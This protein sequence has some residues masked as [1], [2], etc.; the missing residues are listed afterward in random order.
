[1]GEVFPHAESG[2][3]IKK[4]RIKVQLSLKHLLAV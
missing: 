4:K 3:K 1:M 2:E